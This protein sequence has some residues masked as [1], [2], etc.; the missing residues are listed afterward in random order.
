MMQITATMS[1][2]YNDDNDDDDVVV[3]LAARTNALLSVCLIE[4]FILYT[5]NYPN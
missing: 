3:V 4:P 5:F 2:W 1:P